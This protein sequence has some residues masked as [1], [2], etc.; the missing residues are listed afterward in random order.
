MNCLEFRK[1][2]LT[3]PNT[4]SADM[5]AHREACADCA[6]FARRVESLEQ[7]LTAATLIEPPEGLAER[8]LL[9]QS[10]G[11][12]PPL[13]TRRRLLSLAASVA[14]ASIGLGS[15]L[16][17][18]RGS[19]DSLSQPDIARELVAH[20]LG[21][22]PPG[23][24]AASGAVPRTTVKELLARAG[25]AATAELGVVANAWPCDFRGEPIAHLVLP[26]QAGPMVAL[27]LPQAV[28]ARSHEFAG[29]YLDG[30]IMPCGRG[31]LALMAQTD[32]DLDRVAIH[33]HSVLE[34]V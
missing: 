22:H 32:T 23:L 1:L 30:V 24:G 19:Q 8:V 9:R 7:A 21:T 10:L 25:F 2:L 12:A 11:D 15:L 31:T 6:A 5:Q 33:L 3:Q 17:W 4:L 34:S 26:G 28:A 16:Y 18:R 13:P 27:V 29:P 14:V 20:L